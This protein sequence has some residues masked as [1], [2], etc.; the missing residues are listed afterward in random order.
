ME[1]SARHQINMKVLR[2]HDKA[3]VDII[4]SA[5]FV[6]LYSH[7]GE[8]TKTGIEG[9]MF[10]YRRSVNPP[11]GFFVL[12]RNGVENFSANLTTEDDLELTTEFIIYRASQGERRRCWDLDIRTGTEGELQATPLITTA[13]ALDPLADASAQSKAAP[14]AHASQSISLDALFG[15]ASKS[16]ER[17]GPTKSTN[18]LSL[19][20]SIFDSASPQKIS[21]KAAN[22]ADASSTPHSTSHSDGAEDLKALL[23]LQSSAI[24]PSALPKPTASTPSGLEALFASTSV[25]ASRIPPETKLEQVM[26]GKTS[27]VR[28][29]AADLVDASLQSR[30]E[31]SAATLVDSLSRRDFVREVLSLIHTDKDFVDDLYQRYQNKSHQ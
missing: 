13:S 9:P 1:D 21:A 20:E 4:E 12:N 24:K 18:G 19:L 31:G 29:S 23:G 10:L 11:Y 7:N 3:I 2:R 8:W 30:R 5:S 25:S 17:A 28:G 22:L 26:N 6:V 15:S 14:S 16:S 27:A